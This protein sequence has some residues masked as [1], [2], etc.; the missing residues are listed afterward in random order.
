MEHKSQ[1]KN[2]FAPDGSDYAL[3]LLWR[4]SVSFL[5]WCFLHTHTTVHVE[6]EGSRNCIYLS[7]ESLF[8]NAAQLIIKRCVSGAVLSRKY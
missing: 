5:F 6:G 8:L 3:C 4:S 7:V 1:E 2:A